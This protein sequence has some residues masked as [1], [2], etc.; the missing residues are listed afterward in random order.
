MKRLLRIA[1]QVLTLSDR[2]SSTPSGEELR[3]DGEASAVALLTRYARDATNLIALRSYL[4]GQLTAI[5]LHRL[6]DAEVVA[7]VAR[8][9][10]GRSALA[11]QRSLP[12][13]DTFGGDVEL[14]TDAASA[15]EPAPSVKTWIEIELVDLEG[16][17]VKGARYWIQ[18]PDGSIHEGWLDHRG[19]ARVDDLD[20][21]V[22]E[23]RWPDH[24]E[25][26]VALATIAL[27]PPPPEEVPF[28][29]GAL[30]PSEIDAAAQAHALEQAARDGVPF[31]EECE[32]LKKKRQSPA[33]EA[34]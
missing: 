30:T 23:I 27:A 31:C 33:M 22:C 9:L 15:R 14:E 24:D 13:L 8:A 2:L 19:Q 6:S 26:A 4:A 29:P 20:P 16:E 32:K 11:F 18:L 3:F 7:A 28:D 1:G 17:P 12:P 5:P 25:E 10:A 34:R 21:G